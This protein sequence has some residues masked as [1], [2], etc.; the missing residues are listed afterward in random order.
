MAILS[1]FRRGK[2]AAANMAITGSGALRFISIGNFYGRCEP[3]PN[4][5]YMLAW[6]DG[7]GAGRGGARSD[8]KGRYL[9]IDQDRV[10]ADGQMER[11]ND[12][13]VADNGV[14][15][16][17]DW[18]F[19]T[20]EL[21]GTFCAFRPDGTEILRR[22]FL[23][24]LYNCG[25]S[26]DGRLA[27]CQTCNSPSERDSSMLT[28]FDLDK[29]V[30]IASWHPE[31][32]WATGYNFSVDGAHLSLTY[33]QGPPLLYTSAGEFVDRPLWIESS[34]DRG[35][36]YMV[37]RVIKE[38]HPR[39]EGAFA[40]RLVGCIDKGL[41]A[42]RADDLRT[43]AFGLKLKATCLDGLEDWTV[44]LTIYEEALALDPKLGVK[45]RIEQLRRKL[46]PHA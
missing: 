46:T 32:G 34:L 22:K 43:R 21:R 25:I 4:G 45:R 42:V 10:I 23:A 8:G 35:D 7:D 9:L 6:R 28:L 26:R 19:F 15:V 24:N 39:P 5:R 16:L 11:P 17:N 18:R 12:G 40:Q 14:F 33:N 44:A 30:E 13:H 27:C 38:T 37:Q 29:A 31:S 20:S 1:W 41:A 3:S 36:L 2:P